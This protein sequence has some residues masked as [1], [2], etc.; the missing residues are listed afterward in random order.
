MVKYYSLHAHTFYWLEIWSAYSTWSSACF[1]EERK[2]FCLLAGHAWKANIV[3]CKWKSLV[4]GYFYN[5]FFP[6]RQVRLERHWNSCISFR[7]KKQS[8]RGNNA[9]PLQTVVKVYSFVN[10]SNRFNRVNSWFC[11]LTKARWV[12]D[13]QF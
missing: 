8:C 7:G 11:M 12:C 3:A 9:T 6:S 10:E 4:S 5:A 13:L 2:F 1:F